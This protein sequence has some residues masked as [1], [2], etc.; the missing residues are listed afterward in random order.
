MGRIVLCAD[1]ES[2]VRPMLLG[3]EDISLDGKGWL[4][5]IPDALEARAFIRSAS[6]VDEVWIASS[7]QLEA[8]NLAAGIAKDRPDVPLF[9]IGF[10]ADGQL[11][12]RI[13]GLGVSAVWDSQRF[14]ERFD[15]E[16]RRR[17]LMS[18][19]A[20]LEIV[21]GERFETGKSGV[22]KPEPEAERRES[23]ATQRG[24]I[25]SGEARAS[26]PQSGHPQERPSQERRSQERP[27]QAVRDRSCYTVSVLSGSGG[28]GK[29]S[30]VALAAC[31]AQA[32][33]FRTAVI[34]ADTQF[35]DISKMIFKG[36]RVS[37]DVLLE[38]PAVLD[39]PTLTDSA[40]APTV[41]EAPD[42]VEHSEALSGRMAEVV[43]LCS[44]RFD[45]LCVDTG[46]NWTDDHVW[47]LENSD[48]C[49]FMLDQRASSIRS[50]QRAVDLCVRMGVATGSFVY[51]LN[52]CKRD[53]IF[54][55][56][57]VANVMQGAHVVEL[58]DGGSEVEEYL[59]A[60][61][62]HEL[63]SLKNE[64]VSSID[65]LMGD[66]LPA[67]AFFA[68]SPEWSLPT[69]GE[70]HG[71]AGR[72]QR[73]GFFPERRERKRGKGRRAAQ[74]SAAEDAGRLLASGR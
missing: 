10:D 59:G 12:K 18:E 22:S 30:F 64:C 9:L 5:S 39:D 66:L 33:G 47:I 45:V 28:V 4:V 58:K 1:T 49:L 15:A 23:S 7:D 13:R 68:G 52:R 41:I 73:R 8:V 72:Q 63:A 61:L 35:G 17:S 53:A 21:A 62:A 50:A 2:L 65:A 48:C 36:P 27:A 32:R 55:G 60:G 19:V 24:R 25:R 51:A 71:G 44:K 26:Q 46:P 14:C 6:D 57:D 29:S 16:M 74:G 20:S 70:R 38:N 11:A 42:R 3:L 56:M 67:S 69:D 54:S 34:D 31:M 40:E 37:M 43:A